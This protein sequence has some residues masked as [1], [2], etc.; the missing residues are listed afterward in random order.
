MAVQY[1]HIFFPFTQFQKI[2]LIFY[3]CESVAL[4]RQLKR[5]KL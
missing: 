3:K 1:I 2:Q 5:I 4:S